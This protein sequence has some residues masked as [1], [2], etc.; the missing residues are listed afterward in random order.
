M[1][2][3]IESRRLVA[4]PRT[5][6]TRHRRT[7]S[8]AVAPAPLTIRGC[9]VCLPASPW[10]ERLARLKAILGLDLL[11]LAL[12]YGYC[13]AAQPGFATPGAKRVA[14]WTHRQPVLVRYAV[15]FVVW[16]VLMTGV[17]LIAH[18]TG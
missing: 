14:A 16:L 1:H 15:A 17:Y 12:L 10:S 2:C 3:P 6:V 8:R 4:E 5:S 9:T 11:T 18:D 13:L 7:I